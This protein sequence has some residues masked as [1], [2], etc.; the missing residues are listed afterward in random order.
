MFTVLQGSAETLIGRVGNYAI[1]PLPT[2]CETSQPMFC[3]DVVR[4]CN[5]AACREDHIE[6]S[7][8]GFCLTAA[9]YF[10][11]GIDD[12]GDGSDEPEN[13]GE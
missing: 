12:C 9:R 4:I 10:C 7:N 1:F 3:T 11:N 2:A 13:C 8:T 5:C 6:C